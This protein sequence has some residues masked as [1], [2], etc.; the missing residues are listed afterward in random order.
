MSEL[1]IVGSPLPN[2]P[3]E[4]R[5]AGCKNVMWRYSANPVIPRD[6]LPASNSIFNS[7]VVPFGEGYAGVFRCDDT[8][9]RMADSARMPFIGT[10]NRRNCSSNVIFPR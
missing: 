8:N 3:W 5:P 7:A 9:R 10:S 4:E 6:L 1:K 2:M